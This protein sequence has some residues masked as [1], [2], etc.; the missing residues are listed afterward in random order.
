M[1]LFR[2]P[3]KLVVKLKRVLT[4]IKSRLAI[5]TL[6]TTNSLEGHEKRYGFRVY[7]NTIVY[8]ENPR[9]FDAVDRS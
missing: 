7:N 1:F 9:V 4:S 8:C 2:R 5:S 6:A 3:L